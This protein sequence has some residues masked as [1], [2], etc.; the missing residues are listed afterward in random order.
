M[1]KG[2]SLPTYMCRKYSKTWRQGG[3]DRLCPQCR[4]KGPH[5]QVAIGAD[6]IVRQFI[7]LP[8]R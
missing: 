6:G 2:L 3:G 5:Q 1:K 8:T 7:V 4:T